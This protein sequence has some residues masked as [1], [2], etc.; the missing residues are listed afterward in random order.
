MPRSR[1]WSVLPTGSPTPLR[2]VSASQEAFL[3]TVAPPVPEPNC[4]DAAAMPLEL[5]GWGNHAVSTH[6]PGA[7]G[8]V[9]QSREWAGSARAPGAGSGGSLGIAAHF[10]GGGAI[11]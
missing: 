8:R 9:E 5:H 3:L 10:V 7:S 6:R 11:H 2:G 4:M 1:C